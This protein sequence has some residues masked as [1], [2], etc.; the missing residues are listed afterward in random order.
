MTMNSMNYFDKA[1]IT[2]NFKAQA[3]F[4]ANSKIILKYPYTYN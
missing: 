3:D 4:N 1:S 2:F